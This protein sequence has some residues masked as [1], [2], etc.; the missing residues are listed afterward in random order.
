MTATL[1]DQRSRPRLKVLDKLL[2]PAGECLR[3]GYAYLI[4]SSVRMPELYPLLGELLFASQVQGGNGDGSSGNYPNVIGM[5][6]EDSPD[7]LITHLGNPDRY[8]AKPDLNV[9]EQ[10]A[11]DLMKRRESEPLNRVKQTAA[12]LDTFGRFQEANNELEDC[13]PV[14]IGWWRQSLAGSGNPMA[15]LRFFRLVQQK[16]GVGRMN[17]FLLSSLSNMYRNLGLS[18]TAA[19]LKTMLNESIW[20]VN[21]T[22]EPAKSIGRTDG[23]FIAVLQEDVLKANEA[24]YLE[25]FFDGVIH[26]N[27]CVFHDEKIRAVRV[28]VRTLPEIVEKPDDFVYLPDWQFDRPENRPLTAQKDWMPSVYIRTRSAKECTIDGSLQHQAAA[29]GGLP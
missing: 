20:S 19:F 27:P 4:R 5:F 25:S 26:A 16:T 15:I 28:Q 13:N 18:E 1:Q 14:R 6:I 29:A 11:S 24:S 21:P 12:W 10:F 3:S 22:D 23:L 9:I 17:V 2:T 7:N 8:T